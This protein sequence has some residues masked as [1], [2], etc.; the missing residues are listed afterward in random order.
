MKILSRCFRSSHKEFFTNIRMIRISHVLTILVAGIGV[1]QLPFIGTLHIDL[2]FLASIIVGFFVGLREARMQHGLLFKPALSFNRRLIRDSILLSVFGGVILIIDSWQGCFSWE[3]LLFWFFGPYLSLFLGATIG[4]FI[5][6]KKL[7]F[8]GI[9][10]VLWLLSIGIG[11]WLLIFFN[12]PQLYFFNH[13]WG[14][15]PGPLYDTLTPFP[16]AYIPFR[17]ITVL[18]GTLF[19]ILSIKEL[20][21]GRNIT[22]RMCL[23][24]VL[25]ALTVGY[26]TI[27]YW[28]GITNYTTLKQN[29]ST[30]IQTPR[31]SLYADQSIPLADLERWAFRH[32][33]YLQNLLD[34]L[35]VEW[36]EGKQIESFIYANEWQKKQ[37]VGAKETSYVPIWLTKDQLHIA[38]NHLTSVLE[39]ELVHVVAKDFGNLLFD[40]SWNITLIEGLAEAVTQGASRHSTLNELV[41]VQPEAPSVETIQQLFN[42]WGFYSESSGLSYTVAGAFVEFLLQEYPIDFLKESYHRSKLSKN[43]PPVEQLVNEWHQY[44][45]TLKDKT[46]ELDRQRSKALFEQRSIWQ[47][48]CPRNPTSDYAQLD[49]W[50]YYWDTADIKQANKVLINAFDDLSTNSSARVRWFSNALQLKKPTQVIQ[51]ISLRDTSESALKIIRDAL[52]MN[53]E[54]EIAQEFDR[55]LDSS[56]S[57]RPIQ[58]ALSA[59]DSL[60][61][62]HY[63]AIEYHDY[64]PDLSQFES[65]SAALQEATVYRHWNEGFN[66][67]ASFSTLYDAENHPNV[68][69]KQ[70]SERL[71]ALLSFWLNNELVVN[72]SFKQ[73]EN[74]LTNPSDA[75]ELSRAFSANLEILDQ[76]I[77]RLDPGQV[78]TWLDRL[79]KHPALEA[80]NARKRYRQRYQSTKEWWAFVQSGQL[81]VVLSKVPVD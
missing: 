44:L 17:I 30:H 45:S 29:L 41:A 51:N 70:R 74:S 31:F 67:F 27:W 22:R 60:M 33:F 57:H 63:L 28:G 18:W 9:I 37:L 49:E 80:K 43:Y 3:G 59:D 36:P 77:G 24:A 13:L 6:V 68:A 32:E 46:N 76:N 42:P 14:Y 4:R 7:A 61:W 15:W 19:L 50:A 38:H 2:A 56:R 10:A 64:I 12:S 23:L 39:H 55:K 66:H 1:G 78:T 81:S 47:L 40:G 54:W 21:G 11:S 26:S 34:T 71:S 5:C 53:G 62:R 25:A 35:D 65:Y 48:A 52:M 72:Q 58:Q 16:T 79:A 8:P 75:T 20:K 73:E 69:L